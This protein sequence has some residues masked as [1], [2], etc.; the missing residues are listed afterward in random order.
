MFP[1]D[2]SCELRRTWSAA[3]TLARPHPAELRENDCFHFRFRTKWFTLRPHTVKP[4]SPFL[5]SLEFISEPVTKSDHFQ[6][7]GDLEDPVG[8]VLVLGLAVDQAPSPTAGQ[9]A[10]PSFSSVCN[11]TLLLRDSS[12]PTK[13]ALNI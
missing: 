6:C 1:L 11:R 12:H 5:P 13:V 9:I 10:N 2:Q 4:I 8:S 3:L 7:I